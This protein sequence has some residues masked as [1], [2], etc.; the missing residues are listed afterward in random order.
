MQSRQVQ[1][2]PDRSRMTRDVYRMTAE[3]WVLQSIVSLS[4]QG[5]KVEYLR[6]ASVEPVDAKTGESISDRGNT[7]G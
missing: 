5:Y 1:H 6:Q 7:S 3:G 2:Y 4:S